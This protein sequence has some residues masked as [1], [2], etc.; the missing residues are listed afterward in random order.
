M[1]V[2]VLSNLVITKVYSV[3]TMYTEKTTKAKRAD[4]PS[5]AI[6]IKFEGETV[7]NSNGKLYVSDINNM[8]ILPKGCS[9]EWNCTK[10]GHYSIIEFECET[11]HNEI[12]Y[13]SVKNSEE[14][15]KQFNEL[16]YK[17]TLKKFMYEIESIRD[18]YSIILKLTQSTQKKYLPTSKQQKISPAVDYI[19]K[20]YNKHIKNDELATL[21]GLSTVYFRK[22]FTEVFGIS[23][24]AYVHELRIKKAKEML[25][26]DYGSITDVALSLGYLNIYDFSRDFKKHTGFSPSKY[27]KCHNRYLHTL[28]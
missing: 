7:Y 1:S 3:S 8:V 6:V 20:N 15:L 5:W 28:R 27:W 10:S 26:S 2:D 18:V 12:F 11:L 16:E 24:I 17:R 22:L 4:R 21:T 14:I 25:K 13:F 9:Y 23:P 19:A